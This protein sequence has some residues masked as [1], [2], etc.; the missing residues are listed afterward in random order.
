MPGLSTCSPLGFQGNTPTMVE[1]HFL[2]FHIQERWNPFYCWTLIPLSLVYSSLPH[3]LPPAFPTLPGV[4][5]TFE[6]LTSD[7]PHLLFLQIKQRT[8]LCSDSGGFIIPL[9]KNRVVFLTFSFRSFVSLLNPDTVTVQTETRNMMAWSHQC[10]SD[11]FLFP[12]HSS[13]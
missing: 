6:S 12:I 9:P 2:G 13:S 7:L 1:I 4:S 11:Q 3:P 10:R 5:F 8:L